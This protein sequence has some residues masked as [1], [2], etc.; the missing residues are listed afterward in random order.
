[1]ARALYGDPALVVLDEPNS[2]LDEAGDQALAEALKQLRARGATVVV[3][4]HRAGLLGV[5]DKILL[6]VDG[7]QQA[8]GPR[9]EVL[10]AM[11][12]ARAKAAG[13][14]PAATGQPMV[15]A[16]PALPQGGQ[17]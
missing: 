1:L 2:S 9:D 14:A 3:M 17:P 13:T 15:Q 4:T 8:F 6:L 11:Q 12:Q 7:A 5:C 16:R 10:A